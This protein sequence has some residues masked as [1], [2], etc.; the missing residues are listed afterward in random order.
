MNEKR[1]PQR[2]CPQFE[3]EIRLNGS[4][5]VTLYK[6]S[7]HA[8][9]EVKDLIDSLDRTGET[10]WIVFNFKAERLVSP[11]MFLYH[12]TSNYTDDEIAF[13]DHH[14]VTKFFVE[15][16]EAVLNPLMIDEIQI[17]SV[18]TYQGKILAPWN[19]LGEGVTPG[20]VIQSLLE[21]GH[22]LKDGEGADPRDTLQHLADRGD[23]VQVVK[24][25]DHVTLKAADLKVGDQLHT[26][27]LMT[28]DYDFGF[29]SGRGI[30]NQDFFKADPRYGE[31]IQHNHPVPGGVVHATRLSA[32]G[33]DNVGQADHL[34]MAGPEQAA[35]PKKPLIVDATPNVNTANVK[36]HYTYANGVTLSIHGTQNIIDENDASGAFE[37]TYGS[38]TVMNKIKIGNPAAARLPLLEIYASI[39]EHAKQY[40]MP[41]AKLGILYLLTEDGMTPAVFPPA[42]P[43]PAVEKQRLHEEKIAWIEDVNV[44]MTMMDL[45]K[46]HHHIPTGPV[47]TPDATLDFEDFKNQSGAPFNRAQRVIYRGLYPA[48]AF[49]T[50]GG[51]A[52]IY[53]RNGAVKVSYNKSVE[54][55]IP[56]FVDTLKHYIEHDATVPT[57]ENQIQ[58]VA[59]GGVPVVNPGLHAAYTGASTKAP[60]ASVK[61][62]TFGNTNH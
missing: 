47:G 15:R 58:D 41:N 16:L 28:T 62:T 50:H 46:I 19:H 53:P 9:A 24:G 56:M 22:V 59:A 13:L 45:Q 36:Y 25:G 5:D 23:T 37:V 35:Q 20:Q 30:N 33:Q 7:G 11:Y 51:W 12:L 21:R 60:I 8:D 29:G 38:T 49:V 40:M 1:A 4:L 10:G 34:E 39:T 48:F 42:G 52:V 44:A 26:S 14:R 31:K 2:F 3:R 6:I 57:I 61:T 43:D 32:R 17:S 55:C 54:G 27:G 18:V